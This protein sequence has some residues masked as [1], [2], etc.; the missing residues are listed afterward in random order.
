M[1]HVSNKKKKT[2]FPSPTK[3]A[4]KKSRTNKYREHGNTA[5]PHLTPSWHSWSRMNCWL[6][7][8]QC[9]G[10][11]LWP[12]L[13]WL[14]Q[15][16]LWGE[17]LKHKRSIIREGRG[18]LGI[19]G[20]PRDHRWEHHTTAQ[21]VRNEA[22]ETTSG[23]KGDWVVGSEVSGVTWDD[24]QPAWLVGLAYIIGDFTDILSSILLSHVGEEKHLD[25]WA[26]NA[27]TLQS[28][29]THV[30]HFRMRSIII[31]LTSKHKHRSFKKKV[32]RNWTEATV[33]VSLC[34]HVA[35]TLELL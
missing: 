33:T 18:V 15:C 32:H 2:C 23:T 22:Q 28:T 30:E 17:R 4:P 14:H 29:Y 20:T 25:I 9:S 3:P 8:S 1:K 5:L 35:L 6:W 11:Q 10:V 19:P 27:W 12:V 26:V 21:Q 16:Q 7:Q 24:S 34:G 13:P 31:K